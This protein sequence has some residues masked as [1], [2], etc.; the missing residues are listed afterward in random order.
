M[1]STTIFFVFLTMEVIHQSQIIYFWG[2]FCWDPSA[3]EIT[4][5]EESKVLSVSAYYLHIK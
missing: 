2:R 5:I 1:V 4:L 3:L